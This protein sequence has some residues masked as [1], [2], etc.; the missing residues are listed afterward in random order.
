MELLGILSLGKEG[1]EQK[2]GK[3]MLSICPFLENEHSST[4]IN[5]SLGNKYAQAR[6]IG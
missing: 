3:Y 5:E 2:E 1:K 4:K 6:S